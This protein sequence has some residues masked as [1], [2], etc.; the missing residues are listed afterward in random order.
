MQLGRF[1][2]YHEVDLFVCD[3]QL[4]FTF[5]FC[6][7]LYIILRVNIVFSSQKFFVIDRSCLK[8]KIYQRK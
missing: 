3:D 5:A 1:D 7:L 4:C 6:A 2:N 8:M